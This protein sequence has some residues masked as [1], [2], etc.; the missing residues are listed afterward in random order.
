MRAVQLAVLAASAAPAVSAK[1]VWPA[2]NDFIEDLLAI[3][4]GYINFGFTDTVTPCGFGSNTPGQQ[5]AAEWVRTAFRDAITHDKSAGTGGLD[6][7]IIYE[8]TKDKRPSFNNTFTSMA[9]F[10]NPHASAADMIALAFVSSIASCGGPR[11]PLR[12]G[13]IDATAAGPSGV[14]RPHDTLDSMTSAFARAGFSTSDMIAMVACGHTLGGVHSVDFPS[15]TGGEVSDTNVPKFDRTGDRFDTA[16]VDEY[17]DG[18]GANPLVFGHNDTT[19]SDKRVFG[20]D[21]NVTMTALRDPTTFSATCADI[22]GRMIDAVPA[23]VT[24]SDPI[25]LVDVKPYIERFELADTNTNTLAFEGRIRLRITN[26]NAATAD[27]ICVALNVLTRNGDKRTVAPALRARGTSQ[28]FFGEAFA[29]YEFATELDAAAGVKAFDIE[30]TNTGAADETYDNAGTG[31]YPVSDALLFAAS[32]S[33]LDSSGV[34]DGHNAT[35][36]V[37]AAVRQDLDEAGSKPVVKLARK[38]QQGVVLPRLE[39]EAVPMEK[40]VSRGGYVFYTA[41]MQLEP[42]GMSTTFDIELPTK[43]GT[44]VSKLHKTGQLSTG[45]CPTL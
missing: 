5:T 37:R 10:V 32:Q 29:W 39:V 8:A 44:V 2:Q 31:G 34:S 42:A 35:A 22:L 43:D 45:A 6:A 18:N 38:I 20:A 7:S 16:V 23:A 25:E 36:T 19:N 4:S 14:P 40:T 28:G 26:R 13:R 12:T 27:D 33:C 3:Q 41:E 17:L 11:V 15:I 9:D 30:L 24:L 1:Y 21:G